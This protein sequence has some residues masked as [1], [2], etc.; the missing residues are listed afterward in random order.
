MYASLPFDDPSV[1]ASHSEGVLRRIKD[2]ETRQ[3]LETWLG[4][5]RP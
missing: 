3:A 4:K 2:P 1:V 5:E